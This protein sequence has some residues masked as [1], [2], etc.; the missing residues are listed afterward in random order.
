MERWTPYL[1]MQF[2]F[3]RPGSLAQAGILDSAASHVMGSAIGHY[4]AHTVRAH[5]QY[6]D[7]DLQFPEPLRIHKVLPDSLCLVHM[8]SGQWQ[9]RV[10]GRLNHYLTGKTHALGLSEHME[11]F[12][13]LPADSHARMAGLRVGADYLR[14]LAE[15]D[16]HLQSLIGLLDDG[17]KFT[18]FERCP[19]LGRLL[20]QLYHS[21]YHGTLKRLHQESLSLAVL[22]ELATHLG[23]RPLAPAPT[24]RG[25]RDLAHEA[26]R[27][28]DLN[29]VDPP[30]S[31][32]LARQLGVGETT[33]RR[34]FAKVFGQSM[35]QYLRQQRMELART[36]LLQR[37]WQVAQIAYRLGY[38]NPANFSNAYKA[39]HGHPPGME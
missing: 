18:D 28:L 1:D 31:L 32:A 3:D 11:A 24:V 8:L 7:C 36:L 34:A 33:L 4:R 39:Y 37:K 10:D 26:R 17:M 14:E 27:L 21:P 5:L 29:L 35:L 30:G 15:E 9:H 16:P 12:D 22:V 13:Q 25:Q 6:F 38:A 23:N 20:Q 19:A 2:S